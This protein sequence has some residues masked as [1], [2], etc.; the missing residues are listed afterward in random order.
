M[1]HD[2]LL[3][4]TLGVL[5]GVLVGGAAV[6][7][8]VR[9]RRRRDAVSL[10]LVPHRTRQVLGLLQAGAIVVGRDG[11]AAASNAMAISLGLSRPDGALLPEVADLAERSWS[12]GDA[13]EGEVTV[14]RGV[15]GTR[16][17]VHVRVIPIDDSLALAIGN[18]R[19]EQRA[20]EISR[21]EFAVNVS[22]ELKTPVG[23]LVL[24]AE[25]VEGVADDP[26]TVRQFAAKI[27]KEARRLSKLI[28]EIIEISRL[29]GTETVVEKRH[30]DLAAAA[31]EAADAAQLV[32]QARGIDVTV[33]AGAPAPVLGD[34]DLLVMAIRNLIDNAVAYSDSGRRVT[35]SVGRDGGVAA[36][37]V[38][39]QGI[40]IAESEQE[41]IFERF[42]RT[43]PARSRATG[44]TGLGLSI[45]K[46][47]AAQH[48]GDVGVWS[49]LGVGSTFTLK[50]PL[51]GK[52]T[53]S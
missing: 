25:T 14:H 4:L 1:S 44:G 45:V 6:A 17:M 13:V 18:D 11:R 36:V 10:T 52:G 38:I 9:T 42:Y 26:D 31:R 12:A 35:V 50:I 47:I 37:S 29:Q 3:A 7:V 27:G 30:V 46:H 40:G 8:V 48:D 20:A 16:S 19:T 15:L 51:R 2:V 33:A 49:K 22:H 28:Q 43:D 34:R 39:D 23:A 24:L 32:A 41:R 21:R 53:E 5:V